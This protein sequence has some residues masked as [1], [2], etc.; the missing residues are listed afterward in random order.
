M[1]INVDFLK[2]AEPPSV[3]ATLTEDG[4]YAGFHPVASSILRYWKSQIIEV[5]HDPTTDATIRDLNER[6]KS[7]NAVVFFDHHYAFDAIPVGMV[8]GQILTSV[9]D[10]IIPYAVHLDMGVDTDGNPSYRYQW[11]TYIFQWLISKFVESNPTIRIMPVARAFELEN[12]RLS[13]VVEKDFGGINI[14]YLKTLN[15][16]FEHKDNGVVCV[17]SPIAGIAFPEK[18]IIHRRLYKL[19]DRI[20]R[21]KGEKLDFYYVSAYP[22]FAAHYH[23]MAPLLTTHTFVARGPF[24]LPS[25]DYDKAHEVMAEN[26][27]ELRKTAEFV[28]PDYSKI[29]NK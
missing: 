19:M 12:P 16:L 14:K 9:T 1:G 18:P 15:S 11:R 23:Y 2:D 22:S 27:R 28:P 20:Q 6:L 26:L 3:P 10:A 24:N 21:K 4:I 17:L 29:E 13:A 8:L 5:H 7:R 25:D